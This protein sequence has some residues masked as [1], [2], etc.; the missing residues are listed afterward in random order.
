MVQIWT[1]HFNYFNVEVQ[2]LVKRL[3]FLRA[4]KKMYFSH[5]LQQTGC[6][7]F[8]VKFSIVHYEW[9]IDLLIEIH[10]YV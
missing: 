4:I 5:V 1:K 8:L 2:K 7:P 9:E 6:F 3:V 10:A